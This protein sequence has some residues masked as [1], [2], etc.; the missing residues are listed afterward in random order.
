MVMITWKCLF[1]NQIIFRCWSGIGDFSQQGV[2]HNNRLTMLR[3]ASKTVIN[4][5][6][7]EV[8]VSKQGRA[9]VYLLLSNNKWIFLV[10]DYHPHNTDTRSM[11]WCNFS[12]FIYMFMAIIGLIYTCIYILTMNSQIAMSVWPW[13]IGT[14]MF[15]FLLFYCSQK[16]LNY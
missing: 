14:V 13:Q 15:W 6:R 2:F 12:Y 8:S 1:F 9:P 10:F 11:I 4:I 16:L 7:F 5:S 3:I